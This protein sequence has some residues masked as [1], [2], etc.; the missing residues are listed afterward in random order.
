MRP[1]LVALTL[2]LG[3]LAL[4]LGPAP[5]LAQTAE[6]PTRGGAEPYRCDEAPIAPAHSDVAYINDSPDL[7]GL[8]TVQA[9]AGDLGLTVERLTIAQVL[10]GALEAKP[11]RAIVFARQ[12]VP[13]PTGLDDEIA[14]ALDRGVGLITEWQG[15]SP[16]WSS[17]GTQG[18]YFPL[19]DVDG[20]LWR[21]F[22]G[23]VDRGDGEWLVPLFTNV[24]PGH[25]LMA[26]LDPQFSIGAGEFC[27]R[28]ES[29]DPRLRVR[30]RPCRTS[31]TSRAR[32]S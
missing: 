2:C 24:D 23:S 28:I 9:A 3:L 26:G 29:P 16:I 20:Q 13:L 25:P 21:W 27:Y 18:Q 22:E 32:P 4:G 1:T 31:G 12:F 7:L 11:Y 14:R 8:S 30:S 5:G 17:D 10:A 6:C 15:G 19:H